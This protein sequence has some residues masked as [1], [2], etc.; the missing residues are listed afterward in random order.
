MR[1]R[2]TRKPEVRLLLH[3]GGSW[4]FPYD[5]IALE[6]CIGGEELP[7]SVFFDWYF[8]VIFLLRYTT[9]GRDCHSM[10]K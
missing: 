4:G 3:Q 7:P 2:R 5:N 10:Y 8:L 9:R 1:P 6:R